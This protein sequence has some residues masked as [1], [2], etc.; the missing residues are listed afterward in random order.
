MIPHFPAIAFLVIC[1]LAA[2]AAFALRHKAVG[3]ISTT[4]RERRRHN[5]P[6]HQLLVFDDEGVHQESYRHHAVPHDDTSPPE[7]RSD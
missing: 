5:D 2:I 4:R 3:W 6:K 1:V 7:S